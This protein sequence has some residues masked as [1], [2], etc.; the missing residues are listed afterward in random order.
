MKIVFF[1]YLI[2]NQY[3]LDWMKILRVF[4]RARQRFAIKPTDIN[5][6]TIHIEHLKVKS[7]EDLA[8][9]DFIETFFFAN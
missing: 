8:F 5:L 2:I 7:Q 3:D 1:C 9:Y 4:I 6:E